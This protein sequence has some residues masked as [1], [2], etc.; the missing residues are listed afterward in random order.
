MSGKRRWMKTAGLALAMALVLTPN[1]ASATGNAGFYLGTGLGL[2]L[3]NHDGEM[4]DLMNAELALGWELVHLG[5]NFTDNFGIGLQSGAF[6]GSTMPDIYWFM[7]V[8]RMTGVFPGLT[9][10]PANWPASWGQGYLVFS[11]R[12]SY[13]LK[14]FAGR[15]SLP[16]RETIV[17]YAE[18]GLGPYIFNYMK[19]YDLGRWEA[20]IISDPVLGFRFALGASFY[21]RRFYIGPEISYHIARYTD[22]TY[23]PE[24][25]ASIEFESDETGDMLVFLFKLGY[26][27]RR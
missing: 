11:G 22:W 26:H 18:V 23:N 2:A 1:L 19:D 27:F 9:N 10:S 6:V 12:Y 3:P 14:P 4:A 25:G 5:Y 7:L 16:M 20:E 8:H 17:P 21:S 24:N 15:S 13:P